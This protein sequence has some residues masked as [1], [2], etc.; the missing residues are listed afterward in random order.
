MISGNI[1]AV[2]PVG[3]LENAKDA[4]NAFNRVRQYRELEA[5]ATR[6]FHQSGPGTHS[7]HCHWDRAEGYGTVAAE[8]EAVLEAWLER[9]A[10]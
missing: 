3:A 8:W 5:T 7:G 4:V 6:R 2:R 1:R 9:G 10:G